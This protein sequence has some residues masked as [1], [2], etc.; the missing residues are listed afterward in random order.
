[1]RNLGLALCLGHLLCD[2][3]QDADPLWALVSSSAKADWSLQLS[4]SGV[5]SESTGA[6]P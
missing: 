2:L 6:H 4:Y 5:P 3:G 1:M